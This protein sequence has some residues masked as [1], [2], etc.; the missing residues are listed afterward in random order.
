MTA[1][2]RHCLEGPARSAPRPL[3]LNILPRTPLLVKR[4]LQNPFLRRRPSL[5]RGAAF[6]PTQEHRQGEKPG[7][8]SASSGPSPGAQ[9]RCFCPL[10]DGAVDEGA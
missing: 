1:I 10:A 3:P 7:S 2:S 4:A 6:T 9:G 5:G 8:A